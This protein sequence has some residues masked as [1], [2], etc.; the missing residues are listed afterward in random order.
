[1]ATP[2][3]VTMRVL[4]L[5]LG[6]GRLLRLALTLDSAGQPED[7]VLAAGFEGRRTLD[8]AGGLSLPASAIPELAAALAAL[9]PEAV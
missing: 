9:A 6:G 2:E 4:T 8:L 1:M 3:A 5:P 7:V